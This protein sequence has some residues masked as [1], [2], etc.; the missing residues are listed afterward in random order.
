MKTV[1]VFCVLILTACTKLEIQN[2]SQVATH[3]EQAVTGQ[4][5]QSQGATNNNSFYDSLSTHDKA[6]RDEYD[7]ITLMASEDYE[8]FKNALQALLPKAKA[9]QNSRQRE[10]I[11]T[12]I[13]LH[14]DLGQLYDYNETLIKTYPD[15]VSKK[16]FRCE[17]QQMLNFPV[18]DIR[19]CYQEFLP[20]LEQEFK[21]LDK[22]SPDYEMQVMAYYLYRHKAGDTNAKAETQIFLSG[23]QDVDRRQYLTDLM[24]TDFD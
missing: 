10:F 24:M 23:I 20:Q 3:Q 11:L 18:A 22:K 7:K 2:G 15:D 17:L 13:Y 1:I 4:A 19:S 14:T 6:I 8:A 21:V 5:I 16:V 12:Q 9:I